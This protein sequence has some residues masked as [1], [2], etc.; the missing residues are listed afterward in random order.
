MYI[1]VMYHI[2]YYC[3]AVECFNTKRPWAGVYGPGGG[4]LATTHRVGREPVKMETC[5]AV[6]PHKPVTRDT[7]R[8]WTKMGLVKAGVD[9][10]IFTPHSTRAASASKAVAKVPLKTVLRTVGWRRSSTFATYYHKP[11][12]KGKTFGEAV[13]SQS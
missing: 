4:V 6:I 2:V 1:I 13:L 9:M 10:S 8:R 7:I 3:Y 11:V 12:Q 5:D